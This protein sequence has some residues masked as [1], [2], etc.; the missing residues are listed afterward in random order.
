M[1]ETLLKTI[2]VENFLNEFA[3]LKESNEQK[4]SYSMNI[5]DELHANE[6]AHTRILIKLLSFVANNGFPIFEKFLSLLNE[7][8]DENFK[9]KAFTKP[10]FEGQFGYI[11]Q[12]H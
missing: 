1:A 6:N 4:R 5:I 3:K 12:N 10:K 9:I 7:Q 8:L 11:D 2:D